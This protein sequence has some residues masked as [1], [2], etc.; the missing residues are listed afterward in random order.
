MIRYW[1]TPRTC[2]SQ[3]LRETCRLQTASFSEAGEGGIDSMTKQRREGEA[4]G[5]ARAKTGPVNVFDRPNQAPSFEAW[6]TNP[7]PA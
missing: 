7:I 1:V 3:T 2:L 4:S 6:V 5:P